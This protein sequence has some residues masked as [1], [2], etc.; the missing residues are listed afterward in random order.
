MLGAAWLE[1][2]GV[3]SADQGH[4]PAQLDFARSWF[5]PPTPGPNTGRRDVDTKGDETMKPSA[6]LNITWW[7]AFALGLLGLLGYV[8][9]VAG[10]SQYAFWFVLIGLVLMLVAT[11]IRNL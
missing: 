10:L 7:I 1:A 11:R 5:D 3:P 4:G 2:V 6:P 9:N 8:G